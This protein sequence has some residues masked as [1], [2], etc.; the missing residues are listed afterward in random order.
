M[1]TENAPTPE[2]I[3]QF[4]WGYAPTLIIETALRNR[5]FDLMDS[6]PKTL[7]ELTAAT[8]ASS[9]GLRAILDA[10]VGWLLV[11]RIGDRYALTPESATFLVSTKPSFRGTFFLH[12]TEH[13]LPKWMQLPE[14]VRTGKPA[15]SVNQQKE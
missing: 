8:G 11:K 5:L 12:T 2:R 9:R 10:L 1:K 4:A 14:V 3:M 6:S 13:L 15:M 7:P